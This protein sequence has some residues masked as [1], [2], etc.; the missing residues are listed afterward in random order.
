MR[1][2]NSIRVQAACNMEANGSGF[3]RAG[4]IVRAMSS[5]SQQHESRARVAVRAPGT[6]AGPAFWS[7]ALECYDRP[8]VQSQC[9]ELQDRYAAEV[10]VLLFLC[11]RA[12]CGD[13]LDMTRLRALCERSAPLARQLIGPLR[14]ARRALKSAAQTSGSVELAQAAARLQAA[15]LRAECLQA[16]WLAQAGLLPVCVS[17]SGE[18]ATQAGTSIADYLRLLGV[19]SAV[20]QRRADS[21]AA[22]VS[23][24]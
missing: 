10:L 2:H 7:F 4:F 1:P 5:V 21:L 13:V 8:G 11:W 3:K 12:S 19:E 22:A 9:L 24:S 18:R 14:A 17:P 15:E 20:A 6:G 23:G 16:C